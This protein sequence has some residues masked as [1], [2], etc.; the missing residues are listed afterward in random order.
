MIPL[1]MIILYEI[2]N[3][4]SIS[5]YYYTEMQMNREVINLKE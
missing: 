4:N 5:T 2:R 1:E 3:K